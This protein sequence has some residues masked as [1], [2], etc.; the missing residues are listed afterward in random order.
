MKGKKEEYVD[1][2]DDSDLSLKFC[3]SIFGTK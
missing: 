1:G 3:Q 2:S